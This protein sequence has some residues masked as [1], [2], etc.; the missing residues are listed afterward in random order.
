ML[1]IPGVVA[2][3]VGDRFAGSADAVFGCVGTPDRN[4]SGLVEA[5]ND[6]AVEITCP[7]LV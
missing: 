6:L 4:Q 7:A 1:G 2:G 3:T 5:V